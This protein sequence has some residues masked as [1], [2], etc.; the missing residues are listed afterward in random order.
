MCMHGT[1]DADFPA[2]FISIGGGPPTHNL[3]C[4]NNM[5]VVAVAVAVAVASTIEREKGDR[6]YGTDAVSCATFVRFLPPVRI[7][8]MHSLETNDVACR[9]AHARSAS[10]AINS[11]HHHITTT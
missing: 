5:S 8:M 2:D 3:H 6:F 9:R 4:Q 1:I 11:T 7:S 10:I